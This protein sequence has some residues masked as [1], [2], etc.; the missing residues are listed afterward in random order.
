MKYTINSKIY[1]QKPLVIG[2]LGQL[3]E[4]LGNIE[5]SAA[6]S[7]QGIIKILIAT[8]KL[9]LALA[10]ALT[11]EG[12]KIKD[13]DIAALQEE[14]YEVPLETASEVISDFF[15]CNPIVSLCEK[16]SGMI[17]KITEVM[18]TRSNG[19]SLPVSSASSQAET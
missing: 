2:Q 19:T 9:P 3:I 17:E 15:D 10:I 4:L 16:L 14:F 11:P 13:K 6:T 7:V 18:R 8:N 5:I 12:T 1:T